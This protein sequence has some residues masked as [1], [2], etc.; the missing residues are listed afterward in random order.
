MSQVRLKVEGMSCEGCVRSVG[1]IVSK[2]LGVEREAVQ[3]SLERGEAVVEGGADEA[4]VARVLER[5]K[6]QG[7]PSQRA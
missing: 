6:A 2:A 3:V 1:V 4:S 5:L 7:F